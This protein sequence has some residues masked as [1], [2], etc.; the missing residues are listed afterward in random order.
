MSETQTRN[1]RRT[2]VG[3]VTSDKLAKTITV[4]VERAFRHARY[5]KIVRRHKSYHAHDEDG[6]AQV[7]DS[8][9]IAATRP[10]SKLKRWRLVRVVVSTSDL[11][12]ETDAT[13]PEAVLNA[14]REGE[15]S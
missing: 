12:V 8:V 3:V 9:E 13:N 14:A 11:G 1:A 6:T 15:S 5:G 10:L 7:G 2:L 4:R